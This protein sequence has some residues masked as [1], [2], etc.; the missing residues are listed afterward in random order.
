MGCNLV[1]KYVQEETVP[2]SI[3][4]YT[5]VDGIIASHAK[6]THRLDMSTNP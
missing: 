3:K 6:D 5:V 4:K 1:R 2:Q